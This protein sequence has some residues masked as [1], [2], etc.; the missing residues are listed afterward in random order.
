[1]FAIAMTP[2]TKW[3]SLSLL[4]IAAAI[5]LIGHITSWKGKLDGTI[6]FRSQYE[7]TSERENS[8][9]DGQVMDTKKYPVDLPSHVIN[10][11]KKMVFFVGNDRSGSS[12]LGSLMDA[13]PHT[14]ITN[15]F[16]LFKNIPPLAADCTNQ[17]INKELFNSMY[18]KSTSDVFGIRANLSKGYSLGVK[19]MW[20]GAYDRHIDVIG[21]KNSGNTTR[22]YLKNEGE[23]ERNY[24]NLKKRLGIPMRIIHAIRNPFDIIATD[25]VITYG[26]R[27]TFRNL[28]QAFSST[29]G[30][31][32]ISQHKFNKPNQI[33][34]YIVYIFALFEAAQEL[35]D[36][37]FGEEN[38]LEVHNCDLVDDPRGTM[39]RIFD[40]L[41]VD[42]SEHYL[43]VCAE[44]VFKSLSR[45]RNMIAWT[46]EQIEMVE[47][48]MKKHT[49]LNRYNFTSD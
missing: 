34:R 3:I 41:G 25:A 16:N 1:M 19:G 24:R 26:D 11:I 46:P 28:K 39:S 18:L 36:S 43:D 31:R 8:L 2:N 45:S 10:G 15:D 12:I 6:G 14:I 4:L 35:T 20:Q 27:E 7:V 17:R 47:N 13:H 21:D 23:F 32:E 42:T 9:N 49:F 5:L 33:Y 40:F 30:K 48:K 38:V 22:Y 37:L 44:K 29:G